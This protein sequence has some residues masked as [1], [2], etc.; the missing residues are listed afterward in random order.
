MKLFSSVY[1]C[2]CKT[3]I[4]SAEF[5]VSSVSLLSELGSLRVVFGTPEFLSSW[6]KVRASLKISGF[7]RGFHS[8]D[9]LTEDGTLHLKFGSTLDTLTLLFPSHPRSGLPRNPVAS[10][11]KISPES[12]HLPQSTL[13]PS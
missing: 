7:S 5:S 3:V 9:H 11:F 4:L 1:F 2:Y 6:S 8:E 13:H 12:N 10:S